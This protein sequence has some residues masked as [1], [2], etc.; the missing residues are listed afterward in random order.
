MVTPVKDKLTALKSG[1]VSAVDNVEGFLKKIK[2]SSLNAVLHVNENVVADAEVI[3]KKLKAGKAGKLAGLAIA[4]KSNINVRDLPITCASKTLHDYYGTYDADVIGKLRDEDGLIIGMTNMDEFACGSSGESSA[5]GPTKN[6]AAE[7]MIPGGSSSGSAAAVAGQLCDLAVGS[8]TGGSIRNPASHCGVI[9]IKP[10]YGRVSRFG[11]IDLS[12]SLDQVGPFSNDVFGSALLSEVIS[13]QSKF[14]GTTVSK[15]VEKY[16]SPGNV[17]G[18]LIG[19]S[20]DFEKLCSDKRIYGLVSDFVKRFSSSYKGSIS[21]VNLK[22]VNLSV[23]AYYPLVYVEF[24]SGTRKFDGLRYGRKIEDSCGEEVLRRILGGMEISKAE[25]HG[26]YYRKALMAKRLITKDFEDAFSRVDVIMLPTTPVLPHKLGQK[27][28]DPR[29]M[30]AY[31]AF[32]IPANLAGFC[33]GVIS[34][35]KI[36]GIPIGLQVMAPSFREKLLFDVLFSCER[37]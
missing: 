29:I 28:T 13:G 37:T 1:K 25:H 9:G 36:D 15:K 24:F 17:N 33:A 23:Q 12:M 22:Y 5:F 2:N 11:L 35:G 26:A 18:I 14:D 31:D 19:M 3:D 32:T 27:T 30:Y 16:S 21:N 34:I 4:V 8:D 7:G 10:S 20:K 6:P